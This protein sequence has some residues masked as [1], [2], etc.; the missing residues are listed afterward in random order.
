M[1]IHPIKHGR[2]VLVYLGNVCGVCNDAEEIE[3]E[4]AEAEGEG[5]GGQHHVGP[6]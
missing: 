6:G 1:P 4:P 2:V 5:D 3:R